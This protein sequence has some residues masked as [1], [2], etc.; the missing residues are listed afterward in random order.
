MAHSPNLTDTHHNTHTQHQQ[1]NTLSD[2]DEDRDCPTLDTPPPEKYC[3]ERE[4]KR[5]KFPHFKITLHQQRGKA[6]IPAASSSARG[7]VISSTKADRTLQQGTAGKQ[8]L[9]APGDLRLT[10]NPHADTS[11]RGMGTD[12]VG[13]RQHPALFTQLHTSL[14]RDSTRTAWGAHHINQ[15]HRTC[16]SESTRLRIPLKQDPHQ[17]NPHLNRHTV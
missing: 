14:T 12:Q 17:D 16:L 11:S 4:H 10:G 15:L 9:R 5:Q 13:T 3:S 2:W 8:I 6:G 1:D 7:N